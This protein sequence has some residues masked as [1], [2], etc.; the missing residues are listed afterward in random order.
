VRLRHRD[1]QPGKILHV[2]SPLPMMEPILSASGE[3][4]PPITQC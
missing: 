1:V 2:R 3:K 4:L